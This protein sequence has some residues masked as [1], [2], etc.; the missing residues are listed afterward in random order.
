MATA[1]L[2]LAILVLGA[3]IAEVALRADE[4]YR[5]HLGEL[6]RLEGKKEDE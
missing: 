2:L 5:R 6:D 4:R 1:A 3:I